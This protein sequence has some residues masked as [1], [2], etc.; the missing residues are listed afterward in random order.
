MPRNAKF[1][2]QKLGEK[3]GTDIPQNLQKKPT[4]LTPGFWT[5]NLQNHEKITFCCFKPFSLWYCVRASLG[6]QYT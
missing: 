5:S 3:H 6:N 4:L 2:G 1:L